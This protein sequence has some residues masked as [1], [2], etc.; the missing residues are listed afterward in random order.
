[1]SQYT[2]W[3]VGRYQGLPNP[4]CPEPVSSKNPKSDAWLSQLFF[5]HVVLGLPLFVLEC[6]PVC[7]NLVPTT[8]FLGGSSCLNPMNE[9]PN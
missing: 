3:C 1:M 5:L 2:L 7:L 8:V 9:H 4:A 6:V